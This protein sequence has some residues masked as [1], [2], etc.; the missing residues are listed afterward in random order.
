MSMQLALTVKQMEELDGV[1][2]VIWCA[3]NCCG[4]TYKVERDSFVIEFP[5]D[6]LFTAFKLRF[7]L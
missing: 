5:L 1:G 2:M 7:K 3:D 6:E 4:F